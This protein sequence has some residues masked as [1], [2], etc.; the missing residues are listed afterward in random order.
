MPI[1]KNYTLPSKPAIYVTT[2]DQ[3]RCR[4]NGA[5]TLSATNRRLLFCDLCAWCGRGPGSLTKHKRAEH[6]V[7]GRQ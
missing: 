4:K 3:D 1:D 5:K 6:G 7:G 2:A